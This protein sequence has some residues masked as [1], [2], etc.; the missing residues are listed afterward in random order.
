MNR[1]E[2]LSANPKVSIIIP[3]YNC[4]PYVQKAIDSILGQTYTN[5]EIVIADDGSQDGTRAIIDSYT[6]PRV[7]CF[8]NKENLGTVKTRNKLF[9]YATG[10]LLAIQD[11]DDWSDPDRI[12]QQVV[13][14][15]QHF[16]KIQAIGSA[17]VVVDGDH[18]SELKR[19]YANEVAIINQQSTELG[20]APATIMI[21]KKLYQK[22]GGLHPYFDRFI[23]EDN[24][25]IR[26]ILLHTDCLVVNK[27]LYFYRKNLNSITKSLDISPR[28]L[29][30]PKIVELLST[31]LRET[32]TDW[33]AEG[34]LDRLKAYEN[35]WLSNAPYISE[36]YRQFA[37]IAFNRDDHQNG[38]ALLWTAFR[39]YPYH[40]LLYRTALY[41]LRRRLRL[42][43]KYTH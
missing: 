4:A 15:Q 19:T 9:A 30:N 24:Y 28:K 5:I 36:R 25:W 35:E 39:T 26:R 41:G 7:R 21:H 37:A 8:H 42:S 40:A 14:L 22:V 34:K 23:G 33:L 17:F 6:D 18:Y 2:N 13:L 20:F 31:Q 29:V 1:P 11:A 3:A 43:R 27:P 10:E 16:P 38:W 32:G 12:A